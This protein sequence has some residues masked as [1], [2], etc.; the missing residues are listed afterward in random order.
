LRDT[1]GSVPGISMNGIVL[2]YTASSASPCATGCRG[3]RQLLSGLS[4]RILSRRARVILHW[5]QRIPTG[6]MPKKKPQ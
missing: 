1:G 3:Q 5:S 2:P 6:C 4:G